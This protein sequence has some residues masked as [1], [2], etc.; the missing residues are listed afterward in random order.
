MTGAKT[1][2]PAETVACRRVSDYECSVFVG[3]C[4]INPVLDNP[5]GG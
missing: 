3:I 2:I 4:V 5:A 1:M